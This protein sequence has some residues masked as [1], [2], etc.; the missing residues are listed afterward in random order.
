MSQLSDLKMSEFAYRGRICVYL[1]MSDGRCLFKSGDGWILEVPDPDTRE[2]VWPTE[3]QVLDLM[4]KQDLVL[5]AKPLDDP[6]RE[7]RRRLEQT[8]K[9]LVE[10][11]VKDGSRRKRDKWFEL[12]DTVCVNWR[13]VEGRCGLHPDAIKNWLD[14]N[15]GLE[16]IKQEYGRVPGATTFRNWVRKRY[17]GRDQRPADSA[18][19]SGQ[20]K[21]AR[22]IHPMALA[23][24]M[25]WANECHKRPDQYANSYHKK[26]EDDIDRYKKGQPLELHNFEVVELDRADDLDAVKM[27]SRRIFQM[28]VQRAKGRQATEVAFGR[29]A[30]KQR[31]GGGGYS[32]EPTRYLEYVQTDDT[33]FPLVLV[34]DPIRR[35]VVGTPT[36]TIALCIYTRVIV[37]W[38]ISYDPP[39]HATFMRTLLHSALPKAIP[40]SFSHISELATL[41]GKAGMYVFD[42][43]KQFAARAAQDAGGEIGTGVRLAGAKQPTHK[44]HVEATLST[45]Q[46]MVR[47]KLQGAT[48]AIPFMREF[49]LKPGEVAVTTIAA[50][51]EVFAEIVAYYHTKGHTG[52]TQRPPLDVWLEQVAQHGR[53]WVHDVDKFRRAVGKYDLV[54]F[55][56]DGCRIKEGLRYG[57]NGTDDRFPQSN[58]DFLHHF[59]LARGTVAQTK[60]RTFDEVKIKYDPNDLSQAWIFD[61]YLEEYVAIPCTMRRYSEN[62]PIWLHLRVKAYATERGLAFEEENDMLQVRQEY[63]Q[64]VARHVP[65]ADHADRRAAARLKDTEESKTYLGDTVQLLRIKS[66]PTGMEN[67]VEHD[68]RTSSRRD[69]KRHMPRSAASRGGKRDGKP[70]DRRDAPRTDQKSNLTVEQHNRKDAAYG[71]RRNDPGWDDSGYGS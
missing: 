54:Q 47:E 31:F 50:F 7:R 12:R 34:Y 66:S 20:V 68:V 59:A 4:A 69:P 21:R 61:E 16:H 6:V 8:R 62:L 24:I 2:P 32:Q 55:R 38:D 45:L 18:S 64:M 11:E 33:P 30:G 39:C 22:R 27:C 43:A 40:S 5:R 57:T 1:G 44:G 10:A 19:D 56:G 67:V 48:W 13:D 41:N 70:R 36:V 46:M 15:I 17:H 3:A 52:L 25:H 53:D 65:E 51:R 29:A 58:D 23:I 37:G 9:Q 42:N 26:A 60:K 14:E 28:E 71:S 35:L 49:D 63:S